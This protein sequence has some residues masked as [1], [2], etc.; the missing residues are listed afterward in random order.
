MSRNAELSWEGKAR[1]TTRIDHCTKMVK[2]M[3]EEISSPFVDKS[4]WTTLVAWK[5]CR[6]LYRPS[7]CN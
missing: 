6:S 7:K 1:L 3:T 2:Q 4:A 5:S